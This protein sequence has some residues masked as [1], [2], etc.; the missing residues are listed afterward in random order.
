MVSDPLSLC[1]V[2]RFIRLLLSAARENPE[3]LSKE[4]PPLEGKRVPIGDVFTSCNWVLRDGFV[5]LPVIYVIFTHTGDATE[6]PKSP[7]NAYFSLQTK[8]IHILDQAA[9]N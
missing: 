1:F 5:L 4:F 3:E 6:R 7:Q 2:S 9:S 8:M